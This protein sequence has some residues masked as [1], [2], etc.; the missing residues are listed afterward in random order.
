MQ[1]ALQV[2][3]IWITGGFVFALLDLLA[4]LPLFLSFQMHNRLSRAHNSMLETQTKIRAKK[5]AGLGCHILA[6]AIH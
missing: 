4:N 1:I 2:T 3:M 5:I 6:M